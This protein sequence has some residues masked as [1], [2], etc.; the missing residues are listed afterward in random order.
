MIPAVAL[1]AADRVAKLAGD[2]ARTV[3]LVLAATQFAWMFLL[4]AQQD[5]W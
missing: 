5:F 2:H 1:V 4:K 3:L